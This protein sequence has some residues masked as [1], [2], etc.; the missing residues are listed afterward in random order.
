MAQEI[1]LKLDLPINAQRRFL[2]HPFLR[3]ALARHT[4]TL[5]NR[6]FDTPSRAL[7]RRAIALRLRKQGRLWLQTVKCAGDSLTGLSSRPEWETTYAGH[8]DFSSIDAMPLRRWL[9]HPKQVQHL[10]PLFE[11]NFR[12]TTWRFEPQP[13]CIILL[14]LDR[15]WIEAAGRRA[16]ISEVEIELA[17][18]DH[19]AGIAEIFKLAHQLGQQVPL[20]PNATSKAAR[21]YR[22]FLDEPVPS[23]PPRQAP[24]LALH[25]SD[26]PL[27]AFRQLMLECLAHLQNNA[28]EACRAGPHDIDERIHQMRIATRRLRALL[29]LFAEHLPAALREELTPGLRQLAR[30]LGYAR[31][32]DVLQTH[33]V[34]PVIQ[35][36]PNEVH[37]NTL[38]SMLH[39][40]HQ[41][42]R[43]NVL[44]YLHSV[45]YGQFILLTTDW[46][47]RPCLTSP[48][49]GAAP[50]EQFLIA[51]LLRQLNKIQN[52]IRL[53]QII[54]AEQPD[55]STTLHRLRIAIKHLRYT[56]EFF[57]PLITRKSG[58][59]YWRKLLK[60]SDHLQ[61]HL[62]QINDLTHAGVQ[63]TPLIKQRPQLRETIAQIGDWHVARYAC[64]MQE[65]LQ[66]LQAR[67][68][69]KPPRHE[70]LFRN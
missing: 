15:G 24:P 63:L 11:T 2:R 61:E 19:P 48:R 26:T 10:A 38:A 27:H 21:G 53:T 42:A 4:Q 28:A 31:D 59:S 70:Q 3:Q 30:E 69:F 67:H 60:K 41:A 49:S 65:V 44:A 25:A 22:L 58:Q 12:R 1:E 43:S 52:H 9:E 33:I 64:L 13:G 17:T 35:A 68:L 56:L 46:L 32:L 16:P 34:T 20:L 51:R 14:M 54:Q 45:A 50:L 29:G 5:I 55:I 66:R 23:T 6:Y 18:P 39:T 7:H 62:G 47:H 57:Q 8:F 37:L 36:R 40:R